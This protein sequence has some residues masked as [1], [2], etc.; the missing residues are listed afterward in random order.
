MT[1]QNPYLL[2]QCITAVLVAGV[3]CSGMMMGSA[4]ADPAAADPASEV[5]HLGSQ[6]LLDDSS[7]TELVISNTDIEETVAESG[8]NNVRST[9]KKLRWQTGDIPYQAEV[10]AVAKATEIDPALI[11]AVI[12]TESGYNPQAQS[13]KGA[14]GLMQV[15]PSTARSLSAIPVKQWSVSQQI[16]W[17]SRYLKN[18]LELFG[19]DVSLA[20]AAYNAG[21]QAVK[22]RNNALPP[23]PETR[24][25]VPK[26]LNYYRVFKTRLP[27]ETLALD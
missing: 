14:Y 23:F 26:V 7:E 5:Q 20:L 24:Q 15:L 12:A 18:M 22:T 9:S 3:Q 17:G 4:C 16:L 1:I 10:Q 25:Y 13:S 27:H 2:R 21:P 19:G 11:H 6:I 8:I